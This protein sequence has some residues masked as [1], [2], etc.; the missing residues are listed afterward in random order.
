MSIRI[1]KQELFDSWAPFYDNLIPS[2]FYQA[3]HKRL[4]EY[5]VL[6]QQPHVLEIGCGT[7]KLLNRLAHHHPD[8]TGTGLDFSLEMVKQ[9]RRSSIAPARLQFVQGQSNQIPF[10]DSQFDAIFCSISFLHYRDPQQ[11][12]EEI[13]RVLKTNGQFFLAD[14]T[15]SKWSQ[16]TQLT[17]PISPGSIRFYNAEA[18]EILSSRAGLT[19]EKHVY[20]LGPV[21]L[22]CF[23]AVV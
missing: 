5:V 9:A 20:L 1:N 12:F 8:L 13:A 10:A 16:K 15:P 19:A 3:V 7:G 14:L 17:L 21:M 11:V 23:R 18:R 4:L 6:P 22:S 2:V